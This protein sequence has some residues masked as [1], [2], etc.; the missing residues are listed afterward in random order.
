MN[1]LATEESGRDGTETQ[2]VAALAAQA[3]AGHVIS[4]TA[5]G[6]S[7]LVTADG[8]GALKTLE[9]TD[10]KTVRPG[11]LAQK[12][13]LD[14]PD[15]LAGY[16]QRF[17]TD[18]GVLFGDVHQG[19]IVATLDYHT[20]AVSTDGV[21]TD[22]GPAATHN[23]HRATLSLQPSEEWKIWTAASG[24]MVSQLEFA[25]FLEE[26]R[27]DI[28]RPT[29]GELLE[30]A[31][32]FHAVRNADFRQI[33]RT[34]SDNERLEFIDETKAGTTSGGKMVDVPTEFTISI[35]VYMGE[36]AV[37][38]VA[39]FRWAQEGTGLKLGVK[40]DRL[41]HVR[42]AEF[43]RILTDMGERTGFPAYMGR[44]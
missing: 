16:A 13:T 28:V 22:G 21:V 5:S 32:D 44:P 3:A 4:D 41:E 29:G 10:P 36:P 11:R 31:R 33:V 19:V 18:T 12:V 2:A 9:I 27:P 20:P 24:K 42:Q 34:D 38:L 43:K 39:R 6:R 15:S 35:P 26:N 25:R 17:T 23:E 40:L 1:H 37:E 14:T 7:W 8:P 30:I